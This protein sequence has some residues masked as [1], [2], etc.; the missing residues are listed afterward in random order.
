MC[1]LVKKG[2][3]GNQKLKKSKLYTDKANYNVP[4]VQWIF[5]ET[6]PLAQAKHLRIILESPL[7]HTQIQSVMTSG[8]FYLQNRWRIPPTASHPS[9]P[10]SFCEHGYRVLKNLPAANFTPLISNQRVPSKTDYEQNRLCSSSAQ[11]PSRISI[12][13]RVNSKSFFWPTKLYPIWPP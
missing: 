3:K 10:P 2:K 8:W 9:W 11:N 1:F 13:V 5:I 7:P 6:T 4:D 12:S